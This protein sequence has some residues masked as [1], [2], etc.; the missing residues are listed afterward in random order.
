MTKESQNSPRKQKRV[1]GAVMDVPAVVEYLGF[2]TSK[3][4]RLLKA[5]EIPGKKVG[6]QWRI[7]RERLDSWLSQP[8]V[9]G[10]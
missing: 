9:S 1:D 7:I 4:K 3:V 5:G 6:S 10:N 8:S 2:S